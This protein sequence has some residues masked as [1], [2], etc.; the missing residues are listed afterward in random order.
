MAYP[1][2]LPGPVAEYALHFNFP[3]DWQILPGNVTLLLDISASFSNLMPSETQATI[4]GL[5]GGDLHVSLNG[6]PILLKTL[7]ENGDSTMEITFD[8]GLIKPVSRSAS[9]EL[10][11]RW[12]GSAACQM[13]LLSN[14]TLLPSSRLLLAYDQGMPSFTLNDF[15]VPFW[16]ED[17]LQPTSITFV[18]PE[19]ATLSEIRAALITSAGLGRLSAGQQQIQTL[20]L[21]DY[22]ANPATKS[23]ILVFVEAER[24]EDSIRDALGIPAGLGLQAGEGS[25]QF[26]EMPTQGYGLLISGDAAGIVKAAQVLSTG[27]VIAAGDGTAMRVNAVNIPPAEP[28]SEDLSLQ[29]AGCR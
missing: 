5:T 9:N 11:I 20:T 28:A 10:L 25:V 2:S 17:A 8:S 4:S 6:Q 16:I 19:D 14:I 3:V 29:G 7:Q 26:F 22:L 24:L 18:L 15:P 13:N 27:Q 1:Q 23:T 12:D 21:T